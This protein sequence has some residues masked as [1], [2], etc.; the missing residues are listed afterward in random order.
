[1]GGEE[2]EGDLANRER[3]SSEK[4]FGKKVAGGSS[5]ESKLKRAKSPPTTTQVHFREEEGSP[6]S[7]SPHGSQ[8]KKKAKR[9]RVLSVFRADS[10]PRMS[11]AI[12]NPDIIGS[13][14]L[15]NL[16]LRTGE[17]GTTIDILEYELSSHSPEMMKE[18]EKI[19]KKEGRGERKQSKLKG[20]KGERKMR[21]GEEVGLYEY[22][23]GKPRSETLERTVSVL[24]TRDASGMAKK[25]EWEREGEEENEGEEGDVG[26]SISDRDRREDSV[27]SSS[28]S[29]SSTSSSTG[30]ISTSPPIHSPVSARMAALLSPQKSTSREG[31][32]RTERERQPRKKPGLD[33][34][35]YIRSPR[36]GESEGEPRAKEEESEKERS[37]KPVDR[38]DVGEKGERVKE[39]EKEKEKQKEKRKEKGKKR[40]MFSSS[41]HNLF[42]QFLY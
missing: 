41:S 24:G 37:E 15:S 19:E 28:S 5:S 25:D 36:Q 8:V 34:L 35:G 31:I 4:S 39:K 13:P 27:S 11:G 32:C 20:T 7:S 26:I 9:K 29:T 33:V 23:L 10:V 18:R 1:M 21:K 17:R 22:L 12:Q 40:K 14:D 6:S 2:G 30:T 3:K 16:V 42:P 38:I